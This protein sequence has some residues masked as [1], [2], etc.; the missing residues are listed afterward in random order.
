M[1]KILFVI[2]LLL[3]IVHLNAQKEDNI[4]VFGYDSNTYPENPGTDRFLFTFGDSL[5]IT[6]NPGGMELSDSYASIC[7]SSGNLLLLSN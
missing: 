1:R 4:W 3:P 7:D 2:A 6:Y 5:K